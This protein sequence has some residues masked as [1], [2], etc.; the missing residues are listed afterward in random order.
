MYSDQFHVTE[1]M[2]AASQSI[3]DEPCIPDEHTRILRVK[4]IAQELRELA[5]A[6]G[7][8]L[9][10]DSNQREADIAI[11]PEERYVPNLRDAYDA[12]LDI[13]YV[14]VGNGVAM[15]LDLQPGWEEV[16]KSN[17]SK[18]IDGYKGPDGKWQ[19]GPSYRPARLQPIIDAQIEAARVR[20]QRAKLGL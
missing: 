20:K 4:L 13:Q 5:Q 17:M 6:Y 8:R 18:F 10:M 14:T 7:V 12:T 9:V 2:K 3:P 16:Q 15:C 1:F 19:K 11:T